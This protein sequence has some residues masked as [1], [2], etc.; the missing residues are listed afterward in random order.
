MVERQ[1]IELELVRGAGGESTDAIYDM[2]DT[3]HMNLL[4]DRIGI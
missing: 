2:S 3:I 4:M 1:R